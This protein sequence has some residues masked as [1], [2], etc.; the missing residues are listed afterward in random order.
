MESF[1][2]LSPQLVDDQ[3]PCWIAGDCS[4]HTDTHTHTRTPQDW[5]SGI[6]IWIKCKF[7]GWLTYGGR[8]GPSNCQSWSLPNLV[9]STQKYISFT[10]GLVYLFAVVGSALGFGLGAAFLNTYVDP[11]LQTNLEP[12]D[13]GWV[14]A[15][16]LCFIFSAVVSWILAVPFLLFPRLLPNSHLVKKVRELASYSYIH[17]QWAHSLS[18]PGEDK[19]GGGG[20]SP[21]SPML[22]TPLIRH[23]NFALI[24]WF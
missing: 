23:S 3:T 18:P 14:G 4:A 13:P 16:W 2:A 7:I 6:V 8:E 5:I 11:W 15:W 21:L 10:F 24:N 9:I 12:E 20:S 19:G 1:P 17:R 22:A